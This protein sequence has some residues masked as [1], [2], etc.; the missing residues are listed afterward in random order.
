MNNTPKHRQPYYHKLHGAVDQLLALEIESLRSELFA[1]VRSPHVSFGEF[2]GST[3]AYWQSALQID[4]IMICD[5][6]SG[7]VVHGWNKGRN[8]L[9]IADWEGDY[10]PFEDDVTLQK[11]LAC[12]ELISVPTPGVGIDMAMSIQLSHT[13][14]LVGFDQTDTARSFSPLDMAIVGIGKDLIQLKSDLVLPNQ[15]A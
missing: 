14:L 15:T 13:S 11:A 9:K 2:L 4:R 3:V 10:V 8:I 6:K 5:M 1:L 7:E 12:D